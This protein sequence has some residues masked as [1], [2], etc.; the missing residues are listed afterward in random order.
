M[1]QVEYTTHTNDRSEI[2]YSTLFQFLLKR[3]GAFNKA[4][5]LDE[6]HLI[7]S[8]EM[9]TVRTNCKKQTHWRVGHLGQSGMNMT[10][11]GR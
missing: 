2:K 6:P 9:A 4:G 8:I 3:P 5:A 7:Y 1:F 10:K 11:R